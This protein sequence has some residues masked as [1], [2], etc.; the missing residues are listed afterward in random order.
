MYS[1][2]NV[3]YDATAPAAYPGSIS[4]NAH[5]RAEQTAREACPREK[6]MPNPGCNWVDRM[7][8]RRSQGRDRAERLTRI[9]CQPDGP[10]STVHLTPMRVAGRE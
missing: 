2:L 9:A 3:T 4:S 10:E 6:G 1:C 5:G 7:N 8:W